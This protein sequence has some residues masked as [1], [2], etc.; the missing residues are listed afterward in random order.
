MKILVTGA[1]GM[2]GQDL[3]E[4]S[5][6]AGHEVRGLGRTDLDVTD[7]E[8]VRDRLEIDR[9]DVVVN[10]AAWTD[11]DG[12]EDDPEGADLVNGEGA[13]NVA[14]AA[15]SVDA[16]VLYVSTDYVFDGTKGEPYLESDPPAPISAYGRS[17]LKGEEATL[18]A[19][20]RAF[21]VRTSWLFG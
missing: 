3:V 18:F 14:E 5:L 1:D 17:K 19:N 9:P 12:A 21:V 4:V 16:R 11:V 13:A 8:R 10:C 15:A 6:A 20:P 2:L 7:P